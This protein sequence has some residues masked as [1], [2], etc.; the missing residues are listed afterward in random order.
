L[1]RHLN[2]FEK[3]YNNFT[4]YRKEII[5][6]KNFI[7]ITNLISLCSAGQAG[8]ML[9]DLK[10][11][12]LL[13]ASPRTMFW[14]QIWGSL[15]GVVSNVLAFLV[16][17]TAYPC[18]MYLPSPDQPCSFAM[19]AAQSW[20]GVSY[21]LTHG[22]LSAIPKSS[23]W[24]SLIAAILTLILCITRK[25]VPT[26]YS[27]YLLSPLAFGMAFT[28][29]SP[30]MIMMEALGGVFMKFWETF[31]SDSHKSYGYT[32]AAGFMTGE[33]IG[34]LVISLIIICGLTWQSGF[35]FP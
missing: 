10:T 34:G 11:G 28:F 31:Y 6:Y 8:D 12:H 9:Q 4:Y 15:F 13:N 33:G 14:A 35:G 27:S 24:A 25:I 18:L 3:S 1:S 20:F 30:N 23:A 7:L 32:T 5:L 29:P 26:K 2:N 16:I 19:P 21:A 22:F 17:S